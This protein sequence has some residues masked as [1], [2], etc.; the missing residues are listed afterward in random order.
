MYALLLLSSFF[1]PQLLFRDSQ[2]HEFVNQ[3]PRFFLWSEAAQLLQIYAR[4]VFIVPI[5]FVTSIRFYF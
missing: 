4:R 5:D 3:S 1:E 2:H